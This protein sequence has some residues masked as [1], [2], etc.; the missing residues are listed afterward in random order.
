MPLL[1]EVVDLCAERAQSLYQISNRALVHPLRSAELYV[2]SGDS[3]T[4]S[5]EEPH[6]R[7]CWADVDNSI[8][9]EKRSS[10]SLNK[11]GRFVSL[12]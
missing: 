11:K 1:S 10:P 2:A 6:S 7:S 4:E 9:G 5:C 3:S 8:A 12:F